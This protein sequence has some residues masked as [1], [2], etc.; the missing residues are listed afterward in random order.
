MCVRIAAYANLLFGHCINHL[1][2]TTNN[3]FKDL[4]RFQV[5][6]VRKKC[7]TFRENK[8]VPVD[9]HKIEH[10]PG[11]SDRTFQ[12]LNKST[13]GKKNWLAE[14]SRVAIHSVAKFWEYI[15]FEG[16]ILCSVLVFLFYQCKAIRNA[17]LP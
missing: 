2:F 14:V 6:S 5:L 7:P 3:R 17:P 11:Y 8:D 13:K 4:V 12:F 10:I 9:V 1:H 16:S 15:S